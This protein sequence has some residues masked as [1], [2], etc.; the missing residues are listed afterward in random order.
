MIR[1]KCT[2]NFK[3][4]YVGGEFIINDNNCLAGYYSDRQS[5]RN[6]T[7]FVNGIKIRRDH[8]VDAA[9]TFLSNSLRVAA[10]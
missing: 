5:G 6:S 2:K 1:L 4:I 8:K 9:G 3:Y 10:G 7:C